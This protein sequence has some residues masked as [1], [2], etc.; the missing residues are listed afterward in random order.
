MQKTFLL[1][2]ILVINF[3]LVSQEIKPDKK[4]ETEDSKV[5]VKAIDEERKETLLYG[6]DQQVK[7]L[8]GTLKSEKT[9]G[10]DKELLIILSETY[11]EEIKVAILDYFLVM[12]IDTG[13]SEAIKIYDA[14]EYED[15]YTDSYAKK[16][17]NYLS[18]IG[19]KEAIDRVSDLLL[20]EN[21]VVITGAL[22]L[23][24]KNRVTSLEVKL[25]EM[26]DDEETDD[27]I[28]LTVIKTLGEIKSI[29]SLD[30]LIEIAQDE[31]EETTVRNAACY[32]LGAI[33]DD[34]AIPIL[35]KALSDRTNFLLRKSALEALGKFESADMDN[36]LIQALKDDHWRIRSE[37]CKNLGERKTAKAFPAL[38]WKSLNDPESKI[39][40]EALKAIGEIN[41]KESR[42]YLKEIYTEK[43]YS[44][45]MK[46][47]AIEK[48][49]EYNL[50]WIY[51]DI[52]ELYRKK[53]KEKRK[54]ILD[55][56]IKFLTKKEFNGASVLY[57]MMLDHESYLYKV[58]AIQGIRL[59]KMSKY[60]D[61]IKDIS[62]ND[63]NKSVKK[64][65]LSAI[66]EL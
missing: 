1:I 56:S 64:H 22:Q 11:D 55:A 37:A 48:L 31:D 17:L 62:E 33:G 52:E 9:A 3:T 8:I 15:E 42:D 35:K 63:K 60:K 7:E 59:N 34:K 14:I 25:L 39:K 32:S 13:E 51:P 53:N 29:N 49:I 43:K 21:K 18:E 54:P 47:I 26:L 61:K 10:F 23:I 65:A 19:S 38:K 36:I 40:K 6:I 24:G 5:E 45:T 20:S 41:T 66:D 50:A 2:L 46:I 27:Q 30:R 57:G 16:A 4:T 58:Y 28:F 12:E 44:D